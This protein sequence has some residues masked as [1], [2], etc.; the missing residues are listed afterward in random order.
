MTSFPE[1]LNGSRME[2]FFIARKVK[3]CESPNKS[4]YFNMLNSQKLE[5]L[6]RGDVDMT[7]KLID[8]LDSKWRFTVGVLSWRPTGIITLK[9]EQQ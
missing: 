8:L 6:L 1:T 4:N 2:V 7:R 5:L 3:L 9:Q